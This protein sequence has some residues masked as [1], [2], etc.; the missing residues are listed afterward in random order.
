MCLSVEVTSICRYQ[1]GRVRGGS[2]SPRLRPTLARKVLGDAMTKHKDHEQSIIRFPRLRFHDR[3]LARVMK[4]IPAF[5]PKDARKPYWLID[6]F[7]PNGSVH[8]VWGEA[9]TFKSTFLTLAAWHLSRGEEFLGRKTR[10]RPCLYLDY[11]NP[12]DA[13]A[14]HC[15]DL[16]IDLPSPMFVIWDRFH[17]ELPPQPTDDRLID[18]IKRCKKETGRYPWIIFDSWTSLLKS[19]N[20]KERSDTAAI[21]Q[22][23]RGLTDLGATATIIDHCNR[24]GNLYGSEAKET[25]MDAMHRFEEIGHSG[26]FSTR[27]HTMRVLATLKRYTPPDEGTLSF[28]VKSEKKGNAWHVRS[29]NAT[30]DKSA[31][32][33]EQRLKLLKDLITHHPNTGQVELAKLASEAKDEENKQIISKKDAMDLLQ[34]GA[35]IHWTITIVGKSHKQIFRVIKG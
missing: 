12:Q 13:I 29:L 30:K 21:F 24:S 14:R 9:G 18:F 25:Q 34:D 5:D 1:T 4:G 6:E 17:G 19:R 28:E 35:G 33:L 15:R 31:L 7:L 22:S 20:D 8:Y 16:H 26:V 27:V 32:Q 11:E 23:I 3:A 10:Q 2:P